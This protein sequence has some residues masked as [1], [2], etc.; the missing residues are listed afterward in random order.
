MN[1]LH[2][3]KEEASQARQLEARYGFASPERIKACNTELKALE[4]LKQSLIAKIEQAQETLHTLLLAHDSVLHQNG[5][6][7]D[8]L[9]YDLDDFEQDI[10]DLKEKFTES[11]EWNKPL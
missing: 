5:M 9:A 8:T 4:P 10:S 2:H 7:W 3:I 11:F 6:K 1:Y